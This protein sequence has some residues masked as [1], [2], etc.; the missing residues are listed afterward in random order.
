MERTHLLVLPLAAAVLAGAAPASA[1]VRAQPG[2][3]AIVGSTILPMN[4]PGSLKGRTVL[5]RGDQIVAVLPER[6]ID[7]SRAT[8]VDGHGKWLLPG[9]A[10]MHVHIQ[11]EEDLPLFL[12][13]GVTLVRNLFGSPQHLAWRDEIARGAR[14]GPT[15]VTSGR[16]IDGDPPIWPTSAAIITPEQ[17]REEVRAQKKAGYDWI[18][19]YN[20]LSLA[21]FEAIVAEAKAQG[22]PVAGHVPATV[23]IE[24]AITSGMRTIEHLEGYLPWR[25]SVVTMDRAIVTKTLKAGVWNCPT[26]VVMDRFARLDDTAALDS[27][28]RGLEFVLPMIRESWKPKNDFRAMKF[29]PERYAAMRR[30]NQLRRELVRDLSKAGAKLVL[31]TDTGNPYVVP[32]FAVLEE[33]KLLVASGLTP[34]TALRLATAAPAELLQSPGAF[35]VVAKGARADLVLVD[36][37]PLASLDALADP[38]VVIARGKVHRRD[39]MLASIRAMRAPESGDPFAK[40]PAL[41]PT[42]ESSIPVRYDVLLGETKIGAERALFS[43]SGS[44]SGVLRGQAV[45]Q[46]PQ[47]MVLTYRA[48][49]ELVELTA[50]DRP[51]KVSRK[52]GSIVASEGAKEVTAEAPQSAVIGSPAIAEFFWYGE[53]LESLEVGASR[54]ISVMSVGVDGADLRL[55]PA[56]YDFTR[57]ADVDGRRVYELKGKMGTMAITGTMTA[58]KDG[59]PHEVRLVLGFGTW[60]WRRAG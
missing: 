48:T 30:K 44:G 59:A 39:D 41:L 15:L 11:S 53:Q 47:R 3:V 36:G 29:T 14:D 31:G 46:P 40:L 37:D 12:L 9:L 28:T 1:K 20:G 55:D 18:K 25:Y 42:E 45:Y 32:G 23:G 8:V 21:S 16:I 24:R 22:L 38:P 35:G 60:I 34:W 5:I 4:H 7:A 10:D 54:T 58:D 13:N 2:E 50:D 56:S 43:R 26:L 33:L 6:E 49:P 27:T 52:G 17:G 19:V 51:V 57:A